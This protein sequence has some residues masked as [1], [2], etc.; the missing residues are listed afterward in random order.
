MANNKLNTDGIFLLEQPFVRV[1]YENYRRIFRTSQRNVEKDF[2]PLQNASN[3]LVNRARAG[4][5]NDEEALKSIDSMIGRVESLKRKL[6]D[7]NENAGK[8]TLD[9]M[10]ERLNHL[11]TIE[12]IQSTAEPEFSRW[13]DTRLDRWLVDWTLRNGKERTAKRIARDKDIETLVDIDLF[14][15][16]K[17]IEDA[18]ARHSCTEALAWCSENKSALRKIK[19]TLEFELRLQ[20]FIELARQRRSEEAIAYAKKYLVPWQGTH[21]EEIKHASAL[22]AFPPTTTCGP[23]KR[24]YDSN[25][26]S[27][28]VRSFRLA[29]YDLNTIPNEPLLH[30]ALYAGLASLKLP[31]CYDIQTKNVDCPVCDGESAALRAAN[32]K[33]SDV[34]MTSASTEFNHDV[35][36]PNSATLTTMAIS[37][38]MSGSTSVVTPASFSSESQPLGLGKL[39]EEVPFSHHFNSTIVCRITGKVMDGDNM[40][41]AFPNGNVYS[42]EAMQDMAAKNNNF[43]TCPRTGTTCTFSELRKVFIS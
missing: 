20:E 14:S 9:V 42:L 10:R 5:L 39:A 17:R 12:S 15:D 18:L 8:P 41:M 40:P 11:A 13:A 27:N 31:A 34:V 3:D 19:S 33:E 36:Q 24:L 16:I 25:R 32:G 23:Y 26:W 28:L 2:G 43:V 4:T 38:P 35:A 22:F 29:I 37:S 7:L 6:S 1:P 30:L 21:F